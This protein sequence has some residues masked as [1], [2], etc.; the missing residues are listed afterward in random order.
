MN[1]VTKKRVMRASTP[2]TTAAMIGLELRTKG[3]NASGMVEE[4][5]AGFNV[6]ND[7]VGD[8]G[9]DCLVR[10]GVR[11]SVKRKTDCLKGSEDAS[12]SSST[13]SIRS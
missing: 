9:D 2:P 5:A 10:C 11:V 1:S 4:V 7:D 6:E 12:G 3:S 8:R 13:D